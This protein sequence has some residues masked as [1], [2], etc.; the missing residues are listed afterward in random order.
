MQKWFKHKKHAIKLEVVGIEAMS[1]K[2]SN[3]AF[4][5]FHFK[6]T[7]TNLIKQRTRSPNQEIKGSNRNPR[8]RK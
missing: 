2:T 3:E 1:L 4:L 5:I 8:R 7:E 6:Y